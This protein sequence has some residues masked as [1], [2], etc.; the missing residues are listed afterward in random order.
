MTG[1][2]Q[3]RLA[4]DDEDD[5]VFVQTAL[6]SSLNAAP[7]ASP[8]NLAATDI[9]FGGGKRNRITVR[10]TPPQVMALIREAS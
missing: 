9:Y 6:I 5:T 2:I 3:L 8:F 10:E 4:G 7:S 1:W